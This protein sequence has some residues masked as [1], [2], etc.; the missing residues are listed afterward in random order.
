MEDVKIV[1]GQW[2]SSFMY[3]TSTLFV[4]VCKRG[5]ASKEKNKNKAKP[6]KCSNCN[7]ICKLEKDLCLS[8]SIKKEERSLKT[9]FRLD[10]M[11]KK[12]SRD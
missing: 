11:G 8:I 9:T 6:E 7:L 2:L 10:L 3:A 4:E 1:G 12:T 5:R